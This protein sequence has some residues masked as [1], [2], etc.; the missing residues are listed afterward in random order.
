MYVAI[1]RAKRRLYV[2]HAQSRMLH[3]QT[4]YHV[5]SRFLDE[6]PRDLVQWLSPRRQSAYAPAV[7]V[8]VAEWGGQAAPAP[9][10]GGVA[11][12]GPAPRRRRVRSGGSGRTCGTRSPGSASSSTPKAAGGER[13]CR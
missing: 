9:R 10:G 6:L 2:T 8:D 13:A 3:G 5:P 12:R 4:R 7:D 11:A 1:T